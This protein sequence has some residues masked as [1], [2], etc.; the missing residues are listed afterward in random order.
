VRTGLPQLLR[1]ERPPQA[2]FDAGDSIVRF[3]TALARRGVE[4][5][6]LYSWAS[7]RLRQRDPPPVLFT[8]AAN[9]PPA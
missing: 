5:V 3:V 9:S 2:I 8:A 6:F 1:P 4:K 7:Q